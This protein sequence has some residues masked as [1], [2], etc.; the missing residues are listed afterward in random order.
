V[1]APQGAL[2]SPLGEEADR[3]LAVDDLVDG[4]RVDLQALGE[5]LL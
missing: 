3:D 2:E 5:L 1:R 4:D